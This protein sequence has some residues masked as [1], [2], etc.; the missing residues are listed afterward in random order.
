MMTGEARQQSP[1]GDRTDTARILVVTED[2][3]IREATEAA[4]SQ[5]GYTATVTGPATASR[6]HT[7]TRPDLVLLDMRADGAGWKLI[8][9]ITDNHAIPLVLIAQKGSRDVAPAFQAGAADCITDPFDEGETLA[10][11]RNALANRHRS[12]QGEQRETIHIG[13]LTIDLPGRTVTRAGRNLSLTP[14]EFQT[15]WRLARN[16]GRVTHYAALAERD[17]GEPADERALVRTCVK[18]LR[19]KLGDDPRNPTY[20]AT[21]PGLGYRLNRTPPDRDVEQNK[22]AKPAPRTRQD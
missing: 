12:S 8:L 21:M 5:S 22:S 13:E 4:L 16:A 1:T 18:N 17:W 20:I 7:E 9:E 3:A 15:L 10:R 6:R 14:D 11:V 19:R 2:R